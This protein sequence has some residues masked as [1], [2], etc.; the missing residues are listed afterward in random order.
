MSDEDIKFIKYLIKNKGLCNSDKHCFDCIILDIKNDLRDCS[1]DFAYE[2]AK[3]FS[4]KL[5]MDKI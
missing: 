2:K 5:L 3:E 1:I 4:I